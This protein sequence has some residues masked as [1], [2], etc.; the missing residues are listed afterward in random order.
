MWSSQQHAMLEAMG[1]TL[2]IRPELISANQSSAAPLAIAADHSHAAQSD[3]NVK[4]FQALQK[5]APG[6]NIAALN[7]DVQALRTSPQAKRALWPQLRALI[8]E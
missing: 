1:Y 8:K 2:Y 6:K 3:T 4:L 5:A 7:I